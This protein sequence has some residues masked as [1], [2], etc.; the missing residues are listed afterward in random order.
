[1]IKGGKHSKSDGPISIK[2]ID[3]VKHNKLDVPG[4][5]K[6][7]EACGVVNRMSRVR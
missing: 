2:T 1:M 5:L 6:M 3:G 4:W 7:R